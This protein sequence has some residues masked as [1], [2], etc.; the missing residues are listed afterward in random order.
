MPGDWLNRN[1]LRTYMKNSWNNSLAKTFNN[2]PMKLRIY[3]SQLL[4]QEPGLVLHGGGNT[5][6]KIEA[7]NF[8]G[9]P[10][11][12]LYVKGSGQDLSTI[13]TGG[14]APVR[15]DVLRRLINMIV[16]ILFTIWGER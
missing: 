8:F 14:F 1:L 4:G 5:S 11:E 12:I 13:D 7:E 15:L 16:P 3:T 6:V 2:D 10:E 9:E